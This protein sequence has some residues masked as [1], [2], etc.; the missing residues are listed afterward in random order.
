MLFFLHKKIVAM[1]RAKTLNS[2][3]PDLAELKGNP[4]RTCSVQHNLEVCT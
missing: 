2:K 3:M 1:H 4:G